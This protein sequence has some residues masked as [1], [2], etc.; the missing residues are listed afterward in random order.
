[1]VL[2]IL[3]VE[4]I[5]PKY[6]GALKTCLAMGYWFFEVLGGVSVNA[7]CS[8]KVSILFSAYFGGLFFTIASAE[9]KLIIGFYTFVIVLIN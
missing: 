9:V 3:C 6:P 4:P 8:K 7:L 5:Y 1:M 2:E